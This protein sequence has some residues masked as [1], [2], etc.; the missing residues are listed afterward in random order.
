MNKTMKLGEIAG[1]G[2]FLMSVEDIFE[3]MALGA[4]P[5]FNALKLKRVVLEKF[6]TGQE[7]TMAL[8][9]TFGAVPQEDGNGVVVP[10]ERLAEFNAA[11]AD[12]MNEEVTVEYEP[13]EIS[14]AAGANPKFME[15]FLDFIILTD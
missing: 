14:A 6:N 5:I 10:K 4:K 3:G 11:H 12:L 13:I 9:K 7:A 8:A 1:L 2:G 15:A